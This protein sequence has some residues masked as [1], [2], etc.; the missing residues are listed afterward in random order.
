LTLNPELKSN[1]MPKNSG[2][3]ASRERL[4]F[5]ENFGFGLGDTASNFF[6]QTFN[7]F[8][9]YYYTDVF[10]ID[11]AVAGTMFLLTRLWDAMNEPIMGLLCDRTRTR[12]GKYRPYL[13][14]MAIPYGVFGYLIFANPGLGQS[15][16]IVYAY[17]T[18]AM[19][20]MAYTAIN[21]PYSSLMGVLS[22]SSHART[23]A[24]NFRFVG[25]YG[26]GLLIS[27]YV[28]SLVA[29]LGGGNE[30][31]GFQ[32]TMG[33]FA[34]ASIILFWITFLTTKER[35][36]PPPGQ[37]QNVREELKELLRNRPWVM[38]F[39]AAVFSTTFIATRDSVTLHFFKYVV[40]TGNEVV[41][42]GMDRASLFL[43]IGRLMM[44]FGVLCVGFLIKYLDKKSL[45]AF[46][47]LGTAVCWFSFYFIPRDLYGLMLGINAVGSFMLGPTSALVW[48]MYGD[49]AD[50]G[51]VQF[52]RRSTGLIHSASL[53]A[54][55]TGT[56]VAGF[57]GGWM[58]NL[59]GFVPNQVQSGRTIQGILVMFSVIPAVFAI[60]KAI[61]LFLYPL[62]RWKVME[63]E[64]ELAR[65]K[66]LDVA[67]Q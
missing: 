47:T 50:Y 43:S 59:A 58:L 12:W 32:Y 40:R 66:T 7:I 37:K 24:S 28:R 22:P 61:M 42:L 15:G 60:G 4:S 27:M 53:F 51:E 44:M 49:V 57:L 33:L 13:L 21:V 11:A 25:A 54:L 45:S 2:A 5:L 39:F 64:Q 41:F 1:Y 48:S 65:R 63:N 18:Y 17:F 31:R 34:L 19:M 9:L 16:K 30:L 20:M 14:W 23:I 38:L 29:R 67:S 8:L 10:G 62:N 46:L 3:P 6:F 52:G 56:V 26:G 55:K 36:Q 35:V